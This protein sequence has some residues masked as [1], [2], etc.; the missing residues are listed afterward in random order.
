MLLRIMTV[1]IVAVSVV[2]VVVKVVIGVI[3]QFTVAVARVM[4]GAAAGKRAIGVSADVVAPA[5]FASCTKVNV[6]SASF[7]LK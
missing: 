7:R 6:M 1:I 5:F 4:E 2:V 3:I